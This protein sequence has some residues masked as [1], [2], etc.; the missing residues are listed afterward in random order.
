MQISLTMKD[1]GKSNEIHIVGLSRLHFYAPPESLRRFLVLTS[2]IYLYSR[3]YNVKTDTRLT[4]ANIVTVKRQKIT[5]TNT[6]YYSTSSCF[7]CYLLNFYRLAFFEKK[8]KKIFTK[9]KRRIKKRF[10]C[11]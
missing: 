4:C 9:E 10:H 2:K 3:F 1:I 7:S 6:H 8:I 5:Y 11:A